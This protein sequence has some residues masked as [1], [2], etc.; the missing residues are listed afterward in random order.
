M[1]V[2]GGMMESAVAGLGIS[3]ALAF[4]VGAYF[5]AVWDSRREGAEVDQ[6]VGIKIVLFTLALAALAIASGGATTLLHYM[7][8]GAKTGS[9][10]IKSGL[11]GLVSGGLI[12]AG[13]ALAMLPRT[14]MAERPKVTRLALG[15]VGAMAGSV[16][17]LFF[18]SFVGIMINGGGAPWA[19]KSGFLAP[20]IVYGAIAFLAVNKLGAMSGWTSAPAR[21]AMPQGG[22]GGY[23]PGGGGMP[24]QG[25]PPQ[26]GGMPQ[27]YPPQQQQGGGYPPQQQ[28]GGYPPQQ[29]Q[30]GYPPQGQ[31]G[32]GYPPQGG[33]GHQPR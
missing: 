26:Q 28:Q 29:Q 6:Q 13:I 2:L 16:A 30:G 20:V 10:N 21:P 23:P 7:A 8:S 9:S 31:G 22:H 18:A 17:I 33:G 24:Q 15:F 11:A 32:G 14:N 1:G 12:L 5:F 4:L 27:G 25:Y 19:V 3:L